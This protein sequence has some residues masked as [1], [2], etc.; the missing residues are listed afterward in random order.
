V[1][2]AAKKV[3]VAL[4]IGGAGLL[5]AS[6]WLGGR[7]TAPAHAPVG[8]P[9]ADLPL[10]EIELVNERGERTHG[11]WHRGRGAGTVV[12]LHPLRHDRRA[13][14]ARARLLATAGF[15]SLLVDLRGHGE[16]HGRRITFGLAESADARAAVEFARQRGG[17]APVGAIG[18]SLGGAAALLGPAPLAVDALVLEAVYPSIADAIEARLVLRAGR[19]G[20]RVLA[21]FL[22]AQL[23]PRLGVRAREL[24]PIAALGNVKAPVMVAAGTADPKTPIEQS[25]RF[26]AAAPHP[27]ELWEVEGAGHEDFLDHSP[28][29]YRERVLGFLARYLA[30]GAPARPG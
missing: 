23:R 26:F 17:G 8:P 14:L 19:F 13:M 4:G 11:W 22:L 12:L 29:T 30:A 27:K 10:D 2:R 28:E 25:R 20:A 18:F 16:S 9:P 21:P 5:G 6:W 24:R 15:G 3:G 7:L 1:K